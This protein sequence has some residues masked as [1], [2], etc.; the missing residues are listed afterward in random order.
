MISRQQILHSI[1]REGRQM[2]ADRN[3]EGKE[4]L[5]KKLKLLQEQWDTV[6]K[7]AQQRKNEVDRLTAQWLIYNNQKERLQ[8]K[9]NVH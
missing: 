7:R 8:V 3:V 5:E 1:L 4:H 6:V 2:I 9:K